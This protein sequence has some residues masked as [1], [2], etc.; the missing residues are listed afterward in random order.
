MVIFGAQI[1][2]M[3]ILLIGNGEGSLPDLEYALRK[4]G[5]KVHGSWGTTL[6][7]T[8]DAVVLDPRVHPADPALVWAQEQG[9]SLQSLAEFLYGHSKEK[10]RVVIAGGPGRDEIL[11][12]ILHVLEYQGIGI[13]YFLGEGPKVNGPRVSLGGATDFMLIQGDGRPTS[14]LDPRPQFLHYRPN[15]A[16]LAGMG[17]PGEGSAPTKVGPEEPHRL[18]VEGIVK[19]GSITFNGEDASLRDMVMA[20]ENTIRKFPFTS[21]KFST[22]GDTALLDTP[23]GILPLPGFGAKELLAMEGAKWICQQLGVDPV[24]FYEAM[25]VHVL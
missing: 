23:E 15:I 5:H 12:M 19:G 11:S 17:P 7:G 22:H 14:A 9:F 6:S 21:P 3:D 24:E 25:T 10:T 20:S 8:W 16:L 13:D 2:L 1:E 4:M 18:F